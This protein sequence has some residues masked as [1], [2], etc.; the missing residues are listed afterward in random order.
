MEG[1]CAQ[2]GDGA[3]KMIIFEELAYQEAQRKPASRPGMQGAP[4]RF[5]Q[6][7]LKIEV[8]SK[9][10]PTPA[11]LKAYYDKSDARF[12]HTETYTF[13]TISILP[14]P[15]ATPEQLKDA[16][17]RAEAAPESPTKTAEFG[18]GRRCRSPHGKPSRP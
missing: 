8:E 14:P 6:Q 17:V 16:K 2:T 7:L 1:N 13:Q 18:T 4:G 3:L 15:N 10:V 9:C 11:E 12:R 5:P